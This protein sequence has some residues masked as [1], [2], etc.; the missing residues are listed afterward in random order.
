MS[1]ENTKIA[2]PDKLMIISDNLNTAVANV[3]GAEKANAFQKAYLIADAIGKLKD[4]LTPEY[5]KPFMQLQGNKLGFKTDKDDKGGYPEAVVKNCLIEAV[6][7][8]LEPTG[9]QF[10]I[11]AGQMYATKEGMG[12][13]LSKIPGLSYKTIPELPRIKEGSG[14]VVM[15][16]DYTINGKS[17]SDKLDIAIKVNQYM[18]ADA[19]IG[20]A[21]RKA[22]K[23]IYET[24]TGSEI[25]EGDVMDIEFKEIKHDETGHDKK[26]KLKE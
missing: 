3:I 25:P 24:I 26:A 4:L 5:M 7:I 2:L 9:N 19:V 6:L 11:I 18:G 21:T 13:L 10:N 20:K 8:G 22:R 17:F 16:I 1:K 12:H 23:W 15:N 14:A